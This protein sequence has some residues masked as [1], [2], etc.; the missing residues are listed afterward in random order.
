MQRYLL[1][2]NV[3]TAHNAR[4]LGR[5]RDEKA[6]MGAEDTHS[7]YLVSVDNTECKI[8]IVMSYGTI[9]SCPD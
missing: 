4:V 7:D 3:I 8:S 1:L 9:V 5:A 6:P 2:M